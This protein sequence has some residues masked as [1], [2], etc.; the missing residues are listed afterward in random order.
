MFRNADFPGETNRAIYG[1]HVYGV[2]SSTAGSALPTAQQAR[3][4]HRL[5]VVLKLSQ[6]RRL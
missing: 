1:P 2:G 3:A 6:C 4:G 5:N